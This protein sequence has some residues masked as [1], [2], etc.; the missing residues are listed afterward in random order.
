MLHVPAE[1][2]DL[3]ASSVPKALRPKA[4]RPGKAAGNTPNIAFRARLFSGVKNDSPKANWHCDPRKQARA[5]RANKKAEKETAPRREAEVKL[6][7]ALMRLKRESLPDSPPEAPKP[8]PELPEDPEWWIVS[9]APRKPEPAAPPVC[10]LPEEDVWAALACDLAKVVL[11]PPP[12]PPEPEEVWTEVTDKH[13]TTRRVQIIEGHASMKL[14]PLVDM[15]MDWAA[16]YQGRTA[17]W[18]KEERKHLLGLRKSFPD[19]AELAAR[20]KAVNA[21]LRER[22]AK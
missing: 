16:S 17:Q 2:D 19:D 10:K 15:T 1:V 8:R 12:A 18:L 5:D 22:R 20:H 7:K 13:G 6:S 11:P 4:V 3:P 21:A 9:S 14:P